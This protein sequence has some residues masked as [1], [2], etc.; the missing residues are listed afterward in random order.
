MYLY[1]IAHSNKPIINGTI[2]TDK[3]VIVKIIFKENIEDI[4]NKVS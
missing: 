4:K 2:E 1:V 3:N